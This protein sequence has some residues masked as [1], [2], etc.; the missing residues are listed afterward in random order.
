MRRAGLTDFGRCAV[1]EAAVG[2]VVVVMD[3]GGD[4]LPGLVENLEVVSPDTALLEVAKPR[5]DERLALGVAVAAAAVSDPEPADPSLVALAVNAEPLSVPSVSAPGRMPCS[6]T[7]VS[8]T[9]IA[10]T[11]RQR[12]LSCQ[13]AISRVQ[14]SMIAFR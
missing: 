14:Q 3:V 7:A 2:P 5:L 12:R 1:V 4:H 9:A 13:P 8:I 11:G 10:S 6:R